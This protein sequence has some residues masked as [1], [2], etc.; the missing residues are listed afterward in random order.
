MIDL[1]SDTATRPTDGMRQA[2]ARAEV[3]DEQRGEDPTTLA[4]EERVADLLGQERALLVP[5]ATMAN[6]VAL[7]AL[8]RPGD[9]LLV[10][11]AAHIARSEAG[12]PAANGGLMV[13]AI[14]TPDGRFGAR[15][16][17][18][19][20]SPHGDAARAPTTLLSVEN[21]HSNGGGRV[22]SVAAASEVVDA[23]RGLGLAAHLDGARLLNAAVATGDAPRAWGTR[24]D[25]VTLCLSKGL[26]CP[27][28]ALL[29]GPSALME[30]AQR[31]KQM[32]G[33]ALRQ[34]G[35][36]AAAGLYALDNHVERLADD[37]ANARRLA[38]GLI[39]KGVAV[40]LEQV[41]T[42]CVQIDGAAAG[43]TGPELI[44]RLR[45]GGVL[46]SETARAGVVRAVTHLDVGAA[47]VDVAT[48]VIA[49]ALDASAATAG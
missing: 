19:A 25:T 38:E 15:D 5:T 34:S 31:L 1:R 17:E 48:D 30:R 6:Q 41:E 46:V 22:W 4:L 2:M 45:E 14:T 24:F 26:G 33:G 8:T 23:A 7:C 43:L 49:G 35:I 27:F 29:A 20:V 11:A 16:V 42:N 21:T 28:G 37:H 44:D 9:E 3:G 10:A 18:H 40:D 12:G 13:H 36:V 47:E 32:F 39:A